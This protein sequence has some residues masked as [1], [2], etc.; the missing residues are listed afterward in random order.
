MQSENTNPIQK[1]F[2][3]FDFSNFFRINS[4]MSYYP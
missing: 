3:N 4:E 2:E 1:N